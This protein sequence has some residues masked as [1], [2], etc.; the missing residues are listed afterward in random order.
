[1]QESFS[2]K[3]WRKEKRAGCIVDAASTLL[4]RVRI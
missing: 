2:V 3:L 4:V 1:M